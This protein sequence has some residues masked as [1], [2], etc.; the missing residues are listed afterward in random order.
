M[1]GTILEQLRSNFELAELNEVAVG[2]ALSEKPSGV[3]TCTISCLV[4]I[5][6]L[7][8]FLLIFVAKSENM[9][10]TQS[11]QSCE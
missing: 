6:P 3:S 7:T 1:S 2:E 9:A 10:T 5:D 8:Y 11:S 4:F